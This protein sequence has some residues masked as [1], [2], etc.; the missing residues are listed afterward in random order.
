MSTQSAVPAW[1][2]ILWACCGI[3]TLIGGFIWI[4]VIFYPY[5]RWSRRFMIEAR[6]ESVELMEMLV[7]RIER[8]QA[9]ILPLVADARHVVDRVKEMLE[10]KGP[11]DRAGAALEK[12][13]AWAEAPAVAEKDLEAS[14]ELD[15][16]LADRKARA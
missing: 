14:S 7:R 6:T 15:R 11:V 2:Q 16:R 10:E 1:L 12:L 5:I 13:A 9:E 8:L 4:L 3:F